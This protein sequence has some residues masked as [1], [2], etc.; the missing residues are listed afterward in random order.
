MLRYIVKIREDAHKKHN[1]A[2]PLTAQMTHKTQKMTQLT[3][4]THIKHNAARP[5][6]AVLGQVSRAFHYRDRRVFD[7][8]TAVQTICTAPLRI[9]CPG[10]VSIWTQGAKGST[11]G[12][13]DGLWPPGRHIRSQ[14]QGPRPPI[15]G[16]QTD[17]VRPSTDF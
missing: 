12:N 3:R 8:C 6:N 11:Q 13:K 5:S 2:R 15:P 14:A 9:C 10:L 17:Q 4:K 16:G 7:I 1:S